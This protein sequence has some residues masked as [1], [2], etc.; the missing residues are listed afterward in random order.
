[1]KL[2]LAEPNPD[3]PLMPD[4]AAE[5]RENRQ[6]YLSKARNGAVVTACD[7]KTV[8]ENVQSEVKERRS[9]L[10]RKSDSVVFLEQGTNEPFE[11]PQTVQLNTNVMSEESKEEGSI[12]LV[13]VQSFK[14]NSE[15]INLASDED[16]FEVKPKKARLL[17]TKKLWSEIHTSVFLDIR[18]I[19]VIVQS[20]I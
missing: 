18:V 1:M 6:L 2:L 12:G 9:L 5:Y 8:E 3:D 14:E 19:P 11:T 10:K 20:A 4:I 17:S 7:S 16:E 15:P 13:S